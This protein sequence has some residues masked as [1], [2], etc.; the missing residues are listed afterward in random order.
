[1][2][3]P[4]LIRILEGFGE[5]GGEETTIHVVLYVIIEFY[6]EYQLSISLCI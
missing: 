4:T 6:I 5:W 1:M 2:R 3:R